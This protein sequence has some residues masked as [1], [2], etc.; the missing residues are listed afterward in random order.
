MILGLS[1]RCWDNNSSCINLKYLINI[2]NINFKWNILIRTACQMFLQL[3]LLVISL[4]MTGASLCFLSFLC[5]HKKLTFY[6]KFMYFCHFYTLS[7]N[8][9]IKW[10]CCYKADNFLTFFDFN[11]Y[12]PIIIVSRWTQ[13]PFKKFY[14]II[15]SKHGI[16]VL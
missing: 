4:I 3:T 7:F 12:K 5:T 16:I 10:Y 13:C 9:Y 6:K 1:K 14:R 2:L 8:N 11:N 15:K